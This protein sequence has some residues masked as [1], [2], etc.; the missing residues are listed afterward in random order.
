MLGPCLS[1]AALAAESQTESAAPLAPNVV[2]A[3]Q[4]SGARVGWWAPAVYPPRL[5]GGWDTFGRA[6]LRRDVKGKEGDFPA[7]EIRYW[8]KGMFENLRGSKIWRA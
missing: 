4:K 1:G 2:S 3:W 8:K 6:Y 5:A 7:F